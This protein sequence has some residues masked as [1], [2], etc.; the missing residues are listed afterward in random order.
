[1]FQRLLSYIRQVVRKIFPKKNIQDALDVK[2]PV[3]PEM[4]NAIELWT[5]MYRDLSPWLDDKTESLNLASAIAS[6]FARLTTLEMKSEITGD[7]ERA[8]YI[9]EQYQKV[10]KDI[11]RYVEYAAAKGGLIFKPYPNGDKI[12]VD[13][14]QADSFFPI[15]FD[16]AGNITGCV[17]VEVK[18]EGD[19]IYTRLE[20]HDL[21]D[22]G[23][24][25]TNTAYVRNTTGGDSETLGAEIP[26]TEVEEWA[27]LVPE[28][29][30][31]NV[32][33]P[34]FAYFKMPIANTEDT[35]SPLGVSVY[36]RAVDLIRQADKQYS[37]I[38]WEYE[39]SELA[40]DASIDVFKADGTVPAGKE[41][42]FRKLDIEQKEGDF[43]KEFSPEIRDGSLFN[44]LNK[45]LQRIEFNCGLAYGTISDVQLVEKTAEEIKASKQRSYAAVV[46]I[47]K[48]LQEALEHLVY[49]MDMWKALQ[50]GK[51]PVEHEI[52]FEFDDSIIV[53]T[54]SEQAIRMQEVAAGL[55]KPEYYLM[56]RYGVTEKQAREMLPSVNEPDEPPDDFE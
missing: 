27:D 34:L 4:V 25:I 43:F 17:F 52:S 46:D 36:A 1:M 8:T 35:T 6:E 37:R 39:G 53:D 56:W 44:G 24:H 55:T 42:L 23:Y 20:Y 22:E 49:A 2:I 30:L 26:L 11:R 13:Y 15:K 41:R 33:K 47:Q 18:K 28:A 38:L 48:S 40:I 21:R 16:S 31:T 5:M 10:V 32:K 9:N 7:N 19:K 50:E 54:K 51:K 45:L 14:V 29:L 3:S 12:A